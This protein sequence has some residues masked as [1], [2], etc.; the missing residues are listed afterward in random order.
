MGSATVLGGVAGEGAAGASE[1]VVECDGGGECC[2]AGEESDAEVLE[3]AGAVAL[4]CEDV[5]AGP[6]DALDSL[7]DGRE[8]G[9]FAGLILANSRIIA[10]IAPDRRSQR[11][12][13]AVRSGRH[14]NKCPSWR[15]ATRRNLAS[16]GMPIITCATH[17]VT[18]SASEILLRV[19]VHRGPLGSAVTLSTADFDLPAYRPFPNTTPLALLI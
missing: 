9:A 8:V 15:R 18:S 10:S 6:E 19:G 13:N 7:A 11:L 4:E 17:S 16:E 1:A 2:E 12:W 14:G 3:G 5:L